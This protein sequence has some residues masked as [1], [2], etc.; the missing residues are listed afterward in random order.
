MNRVEEGKEP[1]EVEQLSGMERESKKMAS[2]C[3][4]ECVISRCGGEGRASSDLFG[5]VIKLVVGTSS[6]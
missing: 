3:R 4:V 5:K 2:S 6:S 1:E